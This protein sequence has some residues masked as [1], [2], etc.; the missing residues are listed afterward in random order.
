MAYYCMPK[1]CGALLQTPIC[2]LCL[3]V[4]RATFL[5]PTNDQS[6][7]PLPCFTWSSPSAP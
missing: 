6:T 2:S 5:S 3:L 1:K 7:E 4:L